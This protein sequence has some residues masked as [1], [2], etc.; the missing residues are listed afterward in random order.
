MRNRATIILVLFI[1]GVLAV[2][3]ISQ[4]LRSQPPLNV[5]VA[6]HPLAADWA[7]AAATAFNATDPVVNGTRRVQVTILPVDDL[8]VWGSESNAW[9]LADY[10]DGWIPGT[11][12][13]VA[14]A[15]AMRMPLTIVQ[16]SVAQTLLVWG[17]FGD[18][19]GEI[20]PGGTLDWQEVI[21]YAER[22]R[23]TLAFPHPG[24]SL[25]GLAVALSAAGAFHETDTLTGQMVSD[26]AFRTWFG[27]A[28]QSVPNFNT[29]GA[30]PAESI[31]ARGRSLG[32]VA[33]LPEADW[34]NNLR[35][36]LISDA[37]PIV[38]SFPA[39]GFTFDF[40]L[41]V[42]T[43]TAVSDADADSRAAGVEAFGAFLMTPAQQ[44]AAADFGL[45]PAG[46]GT[47][48]EGSTLFEAAVAYN[49]ALELPLTTT[50]ALP[51]RTE[52]LTLIGSINQQ[53]R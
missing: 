43:G 3:G 28:L 34:L 50:V 24:R 47:A 12:F 49:A 4:F 38:L 33:L 26:P 2:V 39:R 27:T 45:R 17:A 51:S 8:S 5:T 20:A 31:A 6:V 21:D 30:S 11:S 32:Q 14:Y 1:V 41:A 16:P 40:P 35:G 10:P 52:M 9:D 48:P 23:V 25:S 37:T 46:E 53:V 42:W 7:R 19:A 22:E 44:Q 15:Q 36:S 13:S 18:V 29:L